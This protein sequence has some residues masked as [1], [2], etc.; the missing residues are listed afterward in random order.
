MADLQPPNVALLKV[1][2]A[3]D[4]DL[5]SQRR[6]TGLTRRRGVFDENQPEWFRRLYYH[7][8]FKPARP[9]AQP[10]LLQSLYM[11]IKKTVSAESAPL[12]LFAIEACQ[13]VT[14]YSTE[15]PK[16]ETNKAKPNGRQQIDEH[17]VKDSEA[18][19]ST[20][21]SCA[22]TSSS[23]RTFV[24]HD[25]RLDNHVEQKRKIEEYLDPLLPLSDAARNEFI[26]ICWGKSN[27]CHIKSVFFQQTSSDAA[28]WSS[29]QQAWSTSRSPL[30]Q[31]F[32]HFLT[33]TNVEVVTVSSIDRFRC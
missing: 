18:E 9:T 27:E 14:P 30:R 6:S 17:F 29:I 15:L 16:L 21:P 8:I 25:S 23:W 7:Q 19:R 4:D 3:L 31:L 10:I 5:E 33:V 11:S 32:R 26:L 28:I 12:P 1:R 13:P 20:R 22:S 2:R 24:M